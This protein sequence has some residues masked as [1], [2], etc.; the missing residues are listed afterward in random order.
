[1][2]HVK[3]HYEG[4]VGNVTVDGFDL[5]PHMFKHPFAV[6]FATGPDDETEV[7]ITL[8]ADALDIE[9]PDAVLET[10]VREPV[11]K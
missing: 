9:L 10:L 7:H 2:T 5:T 1:M 4:D 3:I 8:A 6:K 11:T